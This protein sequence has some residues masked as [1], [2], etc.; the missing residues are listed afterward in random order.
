MADNQKNI[1]NQLE[2][3][4]SVIGYKPDLTYTKERTATGEAISDENQE[5][6]YKIKYWGRNM[7]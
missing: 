4:G 2:D 5:K 6:Q 3:N 1:L 7:L